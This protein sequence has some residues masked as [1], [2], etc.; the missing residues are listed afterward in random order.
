[1]RSLKLITLTVKGREALQQHLKES[2][3]LTRRKKIMFKM[4]GWHQEIISEEP[5][6]LYIELRKE[7]FAKMVRT[8]DI[9]REIEMTMA[10]NGANSGEDYI[11]ENGE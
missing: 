11:I 1:M 2:A 9:K 10:L 6:T 4:L 7:A 3:T 8:S 5:L